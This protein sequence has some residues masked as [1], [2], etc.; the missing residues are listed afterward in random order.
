MLHELEVHKI[1]LEMQNAELRRARDEVEAALARYSDLYDFAPVG[2]FS[3]DEEGRLF[4]ANLTGAALLGIER[5]RLHRV[6]LARFLAPESRPLY[7]SF[8]AGVF[9]RPG[10]SVC[11][12]SM[13][14]ADGTHRSADLLAS[15]ADSLREG[16]R[17]CRVAVSDISA[18]KRAEEAQRSMDALAARN[19]ELRLEIARRHH[20][21]RS[22]R[23]SEAEQRRL[24][25][26]SRHLQSQLRRLSRGVIQAQEEERKRVSR[27]LHD[28]ISQAAIGLKLHLDLLAR[29]AT[30]K[31]AARKKRIAETRHLLDVLVDSVHRFSRELRPSV[32]DD[33]GL[34]PALESYAKDFA[35]RARIEVRFTGVAAVER[36]T[37]DERTVL[38]RVAQEALANVSKHA[39]ADRAD[40]SLYEGPGVIVMEV[41]DDGV[42][43][44][45]GG[46]RT[47][48]AS[49]RLGLIGMRER[50][51]MVG[52]DF[53]I[54]SSP[55]KGTRVRVQVPLPAHRGPRTAK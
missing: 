39:K 15:A 23:A 22:L 30:G 21:E 47:A 26:D 37:E 13:R 48:R 40:V 17:W 50:V 8:L 25:G 3:L 2:Y 44:P 49:T 35:R 24:L 52:G 18:L 4:E 43:M 11:E 10:K 36:L 5:S 41:C 29:G 1:E 45:P 42:G 28:V 54:E 46:P 7:E 55:G 14:A 16:R 38:F 12:V 6:K 9:G 34:L 53:T 32:L 33:L 20:V 51:E 27:E 19:R 31:S